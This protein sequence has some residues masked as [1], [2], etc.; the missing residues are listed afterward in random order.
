MELNEI[1]W[2]WLVTGAIAVIFVSYWMISRVVE[3]RRRAWADSLATT[4][5]TTAEH[6]SDATSRFDVH[7]DGRRCEVA[8]GYRLRTM[9]GR[10]IRGYRLIV[11]V[12]LR[13]V[14]DIYNLSFKRRDGKRTA[15]SLF[16][17]DGGYHPHEGWLTQGLRGAI[18]DFYDVA[19]GREPLDLEGGA[20][21]YGTSRRISGKTLQVMVDRQLAVAAKI[22]TTLSNR[23]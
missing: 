15:E 14:S 21:T 1:T 12:P 2:K 13:H 18:F 10:Y 23:L 5:G 19:E 3:R 7:V 11:T 6:G 16:L 17:R 22:E 4:F 20:L 9:D 8:Q